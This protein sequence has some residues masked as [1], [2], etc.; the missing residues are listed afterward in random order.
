MS[1]RQAKDVHYSTFFPLFPVAE[2]DVCYHKTFSLYTFRVESK[3][4]LLVCFD[5]MLI[6]VNPRAYCSGRSMMSIYGIHD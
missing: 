4:V 1:Y 2:T 5:K 6:I 3:T